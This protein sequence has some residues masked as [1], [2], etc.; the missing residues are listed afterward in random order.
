MSSTMS[1]ARA[2]A[3]RTA[4]AESHR[5]TDGRASSATQPPRNTSPGTGVYAPPPAVAA[6]PDAAGYAAVPCVRATGL[7][8]VSAVPVLSLDRG[9]A[10]GSAGLP[11]AAAAA[12]DGAADAAA[13]VVRVAAHVGPPMH[14]VRGLASMSAGALVELF[15]TT[16]AG[17]VVDAAR[18]P[19]GKAVLTA[20]LRTQ[21]DGVL[22]AVVEELCPQ[23]RDVAVDVH[24]CHVLQVLV[25]TCT[26]PQTETL[27]AAMC[28]SLL[29]NMCTTSQH[30]RR[31]LQSLF[32]RREVDLSAI[33]HVLAGNAAYLAATQ[34]GCIALMRVF[35]RCDAAQKAE[36][37]CELLP[38]LAALSMDAYANYMVQCVMENSDRMTA[39][40]YAVAHFTGHML[41]LSCNK[42]SSNVLELVVRCCG[43]VPAVR[44]FFLDELVYNPAALKEVVSDLFGNF[45]VQ[46]LISV[47]WDAMELRRV[48]Q[49]LRSVLVGCPFAAKIEG[50]LKAQ[51]LATAHRSPHAPQPKSSTQRRPPTQHQH[52]LQ[53]RRPH[54]Q[55]HADQHRYQHRY[56]PPS[57]R[58]RNRE[59]E[60]E[61]RP[62]QAASRQ[63]TWRRTAPQPGPHQ[64][65]QPQRQPEPEP[66]PQPQTQ[67]QPRPQP[68][69]QRQP[70][71]Q[72]E[73]EPQ[74][75]PQPEAQPQP[76]T[77]TQR[78]VE[79]MGVPVVSSG[80]RGGAAQPYSPSG[81]VCGSVGGARSRTYCH[82]PYSWKAMGHAAPLPCAYEPRH[83]PWL[84]LS[85]PVY[86][87]PPY[88]LP[89]LVDE[90]VGAPGGGPHRVVC[91]WPWRC[92]V[93]PRL[94]A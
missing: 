46:A 72:P 61:Q 91:V 25:E 13:P 89:R 14:V 59:R 27:L 24:G 76:Q 51:R 74:P 12:A 75:Q 16:C 78:H 41:Q 37:V 34:Q 60:Q 15:R 1:L 11:L 52:T 43:D 28:P 66:E 63:H 68:E 6:V 21:D 92:R 29:L 57:P 45:V 20:A 8:T 90:R 38:K 18:S 79:L 83:L 31:T 86:H 54:V 39:A 58:G 69:P 32:D 3:A 71:R 77:H 93:W 48:E 42:H 62:P 55:R 33:V 67:P 87:W 35:E 49:R 80:V 94:S 85:P 30:T 81:G 82:N 10:H 4:I 9:V 7:R 47:V 23:L 64:Q 53:H 26:A 73:P 22:S 88:E 17:R 44:R 84:P 2:L 65:P 5:G 56:Q 40:E 36:L 50:R 70:Q 19:Q